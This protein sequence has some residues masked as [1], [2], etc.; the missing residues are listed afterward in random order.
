MALTYEYSVGSVRAREKQLLNRSDIEAMLACRSTDALFSYLS[1]KGYGE[2][3]SIDEIIKSSRSD[4]VDYLFGIVPDP[5]VFNAL[6]YP[7]DAH[8]IKSVMKGILADTPYEALFIKPCT[9][10]TAV[11]EEAVKKHKYS[12]LPEE[13]S[14]A[15]EKA[16]EI[17]AHT[18]DARLSD[19]YIDRAFMEAQLKAAKDSGIPFLYEYI[20]ADV[21]YKNVKIALR[22]SLTNAQRD[23]YEVALCEGINGFDK[24]EVIAAALKGKDGLTDYLSGKDAF[25]CSQAIEKFKRSPADF[26]RY[27]ESLLTLMAIEQCKRSGSGA[28]P[29]LGYYIARFEEYKAI[30]IIANGI[31]TNADEETIRERLREI[32]G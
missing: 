5:S 30:R 32:Y 27:T 13:F 10:D 2:G 14:E 6:I 8:N 26:E 23:Y 9:I 24:K 21:F 31:E 22:G 19:A 20:S 11:I 4:T 15:C 1:D 28:E 16:Y 17:L 12:L 3:E 29:A 18:A 7:Y 25:K